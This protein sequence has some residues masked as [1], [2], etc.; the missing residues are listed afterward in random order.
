MEK[1]K[2]GDSRERLEKIP[3]TVYLDRAQAAALDELVKRTRVPKST[4]L[5]EGVDLIL[6][7]YSPDNIFKRFIEMKRRVKK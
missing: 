3:A 5:R 2:R 1:K 4:Y 7:R 6:D